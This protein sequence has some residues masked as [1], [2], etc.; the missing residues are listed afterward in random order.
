MILKENIV[1][2]GS[3][4]HAK[5][6]YQ[7]TQEYGLKINGFLNIP[8]KK[9]FNTPSNIFGIPVINLKLAKKNSSIYI[10][11]GDNNDRNKTFE[12]EKNAYK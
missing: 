8:L 9:K 2:F 5:V 7:I 3:G 12:D 1:I 10:G 4:G 6:I 11:I